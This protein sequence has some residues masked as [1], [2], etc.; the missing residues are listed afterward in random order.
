MPVPG[1]RVKCPDEV[2]AFVCISVNPRDRYPQVINALLNM[3]HVKE[4]YGVTGEY[5]LLLKIQTKSLKEFSELLGSIGSLGGVAKTYTM[6][7]VDFVK[8]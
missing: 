3:E 2:V 7:M 6:I 8:P 4:I 1:R 5:D